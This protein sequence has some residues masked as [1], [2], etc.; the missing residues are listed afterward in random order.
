MTAM[1]NNVMTSQMTHQIKV[2]D[3][4]PDDLIEISGC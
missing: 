3:V 1:K 4:M 2:T